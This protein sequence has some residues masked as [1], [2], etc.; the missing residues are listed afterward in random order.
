MLL[1][2]S[3]PDCAI[4]QAFDFGNLSDRER[5][6]PEQAFRQ[7]SVTH[8]LDAVA[9]RAGNRPIVFDRKHA[10]TRLGGLDS[11]LLEVIQVMQV[12]T[13]K[14]H[15]QIGA[16]FA[17]REAVELRR[18]AHTLKGTASIVGAGDLCARLGRIE[19]LAGANNFDQ[20]AE[21]LPEI[22]RQFNELQRCLNDEL[23][24]SSQNSS[25]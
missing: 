16:T 8:I 13:P 20:V 1:E 19:E 15:A 23:L 3:P 25:D 4:Q 6:E 12:E 14:L 17:R 5:R 24:K 7:E 11:L 22:D 21:E 10:L 9:G 18:A 2:A